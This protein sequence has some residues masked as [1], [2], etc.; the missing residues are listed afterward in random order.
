MYLQNA[1]KVFANFPDALMDIVK[2]T[3]PLTVTQHG[4]YMRPLADNPLLQHQPTTP[5]HSPP[6][7][8][9]TLQPAT[10]PPHETQQPQGGREQVPEDGIHK[11]PQT[12][13]QAVTPERLGEQ[14]QSH[15]QDYQQQQQQQAGSYQEASDTPQ[16][17]AESD[18]GQEAGWGRGRVTLLGDAAH[19]TIP[20]GQSL[21]LKAHVCDGHEAH[22]CAAVM[23]PVW[24]SEYT[25]CSS[26]V[27]DV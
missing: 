16:A 15:M 11:Q 21:V 20:N 8:N 14:S 6:Q 23:A 5:H 13:S 12:S 17:H 26:H 1:I 18:P 25:S 22:P 7:G 9:D 10:P 4:L 19:A 3:D 27:S 2:G 24:L